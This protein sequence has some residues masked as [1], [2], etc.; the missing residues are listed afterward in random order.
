MERNY[1]LGKKTKAMTNNL[2]ALDFTGFIKAEKETSSVSTWTLDL[3]RIQIFVKK[4]NLLVHGLQS[5]F[6]FDHGSICVDNFQVPYP[7]LC[8]PK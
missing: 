4:T 8:N 7:F 5:C 3:S 1:R 6:D 2:Q